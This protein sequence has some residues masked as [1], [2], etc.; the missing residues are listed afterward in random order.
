MYL[1]IGDSL[2]KTRI[3]PDVFIVAQVAISKGSPQGP[4]FG[5]QL[6]S[7]QLV[8]EVTAHQDF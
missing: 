5:D 4:L 1:Q 6:A 2:A 3:I 7:Y 8:G